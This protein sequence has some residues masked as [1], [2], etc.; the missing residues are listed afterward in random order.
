MT[1]PL[2]TEETALSRSW[3]LPGISLLT[4]GRAEP[5]QVSTGM[6]M[7]YGLTTPPFTQ[8]GADWKR[9]EGKVNAFDFLSSFG[10][11][12]PSER[13]VGVQPPWIFSYSARTASP[14]P[15][16]LTQASPALH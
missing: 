14:P 13:P 5:V 11:S 6:R 2:H 16:P 3:V 15:L 7:R 12:P 1:S 8:T 4:Q 9:S 10:V